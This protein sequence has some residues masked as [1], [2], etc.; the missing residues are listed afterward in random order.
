VKKALTYQQIYDKYYSE[1]ADLIADIHDDGGLDYLPRKDWGISQTAHPEDLEKD[2]PI[3]DP[4]LDNYYKDVIKFLKLTFYVVKGQL[5]ADFDGENT[6]VHTEDSGW[7]PL[8][9]D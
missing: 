8:E 5:C 6:L 1:M 4:G 3:E 9:E 7:Q 2:G